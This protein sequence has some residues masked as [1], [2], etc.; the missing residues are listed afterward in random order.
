MIHSECN[1]KAVKAGKTKSGT[2][3][4]KCKQCGKVFTE[5][6]AQIGR[7]SLGDRPMTVAERVRKYRN[8]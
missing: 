3:R 5:D 2:Q 1:S 8:K 6:A 7:P 4:Y